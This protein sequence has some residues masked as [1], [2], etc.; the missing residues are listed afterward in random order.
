L[1]MLAVARATAAL[2]AS[3]GAVWTARSDAPD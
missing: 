2:C 1:Q 3:I